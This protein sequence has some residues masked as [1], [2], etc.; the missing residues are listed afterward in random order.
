MSDIEFLKS[1]NG[2]KYININTDEMYTNVDLYVMWQKNRS[3]DA[4]RTDS[5]KDFF[6]ACTMI[7]EY[8][9]TERV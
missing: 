9:S 6:E 4:Y 8:N 2:K 1:I 5:F 3:H 7:K